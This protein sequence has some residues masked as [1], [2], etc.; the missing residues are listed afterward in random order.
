MKLDQ[1][2]LARAQIK[3]TLNDVFEAVK[4]L[5]MVLGEIGRLVEGVDNL[6]I[7]LF[8]NMFHQVQPNA[9]F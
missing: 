2:S 3:N 8:I 1:D 9:C 5:P 6:I 4:S 7:G